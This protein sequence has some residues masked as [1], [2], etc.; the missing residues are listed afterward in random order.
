MEGIPD[1]NGIGEPNLDSNPF[2]SGPAL[3]LPPG[4]PPIPAMPSSMMGGQM[5]QMGMPPPM[6]GQPMMGGPPPFFPGGGLMPNPWGPPM[7]GPPPILGANPPPLFPINIGI[8]SPS[9]G[10]AP[11]VS[12]GSGPF[13]PR[14]P[15]SAPSPMISPVAMAPS[16]APVLNNGQFHMVYDDENVSME[17]KRAELEKYRYNEEKIKEQVTKMNSNI[18]SRLSSMKGL[19]MNG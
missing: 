8:P 7:G 14:T 10:S 19:A 2:A 6:M 3:V 17:E 12:P 13:L 9:S 5:G 11:I 1:E 18:E 4:V 16:L 15:T